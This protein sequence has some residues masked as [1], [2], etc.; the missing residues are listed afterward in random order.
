MT[1]RIPEYKDWIPSDNT[2]VPS[3]YPA[4]LKKL[5]GYPPLPYGTIALKSRIIGTKAA[6]KKGAETR[7]NVQPQVTLPTTI[8]LATAMSFAA[9][10]IPVT[11]TVHPTFTLMTHS[12]I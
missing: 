3:I 6:K 11:A 2:V 5:G 9:G 12:T 10:A 4:S 7:P 1:F 8:T